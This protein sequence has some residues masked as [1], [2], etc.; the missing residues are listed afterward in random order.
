MQELQSI[1][2]NTSCINCGICCILHCKLEY[3]LRKKITALTLEKETD[4]KES[5]PEDLLFRIF[6]NE[7][8]LK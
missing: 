4:K 7:T 5:T 2:W 1:A 3:N 8:I 6:I